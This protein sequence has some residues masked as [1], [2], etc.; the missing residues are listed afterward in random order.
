MGTL[1]GKSGET[2]ITWYISH[3]IEEPRLDL[4]NRRD[5][6]RHDGIETLAAVYSSEFENINQN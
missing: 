6:D 2:A 3:V 4:S 1:I 5:Y